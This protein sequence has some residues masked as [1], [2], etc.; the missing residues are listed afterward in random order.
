[1]PELV[2]S[3]V[4]SLP[5]TSGAEGTMVCPFTRK[6]SRKSRRISEVLGEAMPGAAV[7]AWDVVLMAWN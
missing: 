1:M 4:G 3:R 5:G 6:K 2:N 7:L